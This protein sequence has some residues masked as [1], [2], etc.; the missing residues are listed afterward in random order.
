MN[1]SLELVGTWEEISQH[2]A[3]LA[4]RI[5]RVTVLEPVDTKPRQGGPCEATEAGKA[6]LPDAPSDTQEGP[7]PIDLPRPANGEVMP[8][9][10]ADMRL[11][12]PPIFWNERS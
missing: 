10:I 1:E 8:Y 5:L 2:S 3:E 11:P 7:P 9:Q 6:R 4:G 12:D